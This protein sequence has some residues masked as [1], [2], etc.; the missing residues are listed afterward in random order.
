MYITL[1]LIFILVIETKINSVTNMWWILFVISTPFGKFSLT[2]LDAQQGGWYT[3]QVYWN[4]DQSNGPSSRMC[5]VAHYTR[6][7]NITLSQM[8]IKTIMRCHLIMTITKKSTNKKC[9]RRFGEKGT[10]TA[11]R[12]RNWYNYCGEQYDSSFKN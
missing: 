11:G 1:K 8:Q 5:Y 7:K 10:L 4:L 12:K 3:C 2:N 9:W 6:W